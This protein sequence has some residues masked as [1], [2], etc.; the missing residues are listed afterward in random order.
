M[1]IYS[2]VEIDAASQ[3]FDYPNYLDF[4]RKTGQKHVPLSPQNY[5]LIRQI[6]DNMIDEAMNQQKELFE[7]YYD[8]LRT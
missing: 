1:S 6:M 7:G 2:T 5:S 8:E 4:L 3:D